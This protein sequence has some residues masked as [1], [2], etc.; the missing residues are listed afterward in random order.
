[1][2]CPVTPLS[3]SPNAEKFPDGAGIW[4]TR[5]GRFWISRRLSAYKYGK[6]WQICPRSSERCTLEQT[7]RT[8]IW[9]D[10]NQLTEAT[11]ERRRDAVSALTAALAVSPLDEF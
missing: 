7:R 4:M 5:C 10:R 8:G 1:M 11:F 2:P 9:M 3:R 6:V